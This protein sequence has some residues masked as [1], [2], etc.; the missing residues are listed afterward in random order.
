MSIDGGGRASGFG[1]LG[2]F[3]ARPQMPLELKGMLDTVMAAQ[4]STL[5]SFI[6]EFTSRVNM[7]VSTE[8]QKVTALIAA[9]VQ[10]QG[11]LLDDVVQRL[12]KLECDRDDVPRSSGPS[13]MVDGGRVGGPV[14]GEASV[15]GFQGEGRVLAGGVA[16]PAVDPWGTYFRNQRDV[17]SGPR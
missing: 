5:K 11:S 15:R 17:F 12:R 6:S 13:R 10:Q 8:I 14:Q 9:S 2:V 1:T 7:H 3:A 4:E 16:R